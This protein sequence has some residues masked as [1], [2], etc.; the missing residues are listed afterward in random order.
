MLADTPMNDELPERLTDWKMRCSARARRWRACARRTRGCKSRGAAAW[1]T[2]VARWSDR[3][4][5]FSKDIGRLDLGDGRR[6]NEPRPDRDE[7][8]RANA[9]RFVRGVARVSPPARRISGRARR[10]AQPR[11]DEGSD[12]RAVRWPRSTSPT[13]CSAPARTRAARTA[14]WASASA[15]WSRCST[16]WRPVRRRPAAPDAVEVVMVTLET[17]RLRLRAFRQDDFRRT[18]DLRRCRGDAVSR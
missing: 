10:R 7:L 15:R 4:T 14:T 2:S 6:M 8:A 11:R 13:S 9:D 1:M 12:G 16:A 5:R 18:R 3:W 17:E